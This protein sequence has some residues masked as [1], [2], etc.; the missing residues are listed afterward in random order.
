MHVGA[1]CLRRW[2][3]WLPLCELSSGDHVKSFLCFLS[4]TNFI[5]SFIFLFCHFSLCWPNIFSIFSVLLVLAI[6]YR[7]PC[8]VFL[9]V[10]SWHM[11]KLPQTSDFSK[12]VLF[13]PSC[14]LIS[15]VPHLL[16]SVYVIALPHPPHRIPWFLFLLK[17]LYLSRFCRVFPM[18]H[19]LIQLFIFFTI[20]VLVLQGML[21]PPPQLRS[22]LLPLIYVLTVL[23][24]SSNVLFSLYTFWVSLCRFS[25]I[26]AQ[27]WTLPANLRLSIS[28]YIWTPCSTSVSQSHYYFQYY[29]KQIW[30]Q[31]ASVRLSPAVVK[32]SISFLSSLIIRTLHEMF[33]ISLII[34]F[35][36][37]PYFQN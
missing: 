31:H 7:F 11:S 37:M 19:W 15:W 29:I 13:W 14:C 5:T 33:P 24:F 34:S 8:M 27:R 30:Q 20:P 1:C 12:T 2:R 25:L 6:W 10:C 16:Q 22:L 18:Q 28:L 9:H 17:N 36:K 23:I 4:Y 21:I 26:Q 3:F 35:S 32:H